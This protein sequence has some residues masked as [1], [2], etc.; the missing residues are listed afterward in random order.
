[1][2]FSP[3]NVYEFVFFFHQE[4]RVR[5]VLHKWC[6]DS[7]GDPSSRTSMLC[8]VSS[9]EV[10]DTAGICDGERANKAVS[11]QKRKKIVIGELMKVG[12][13]KSMFFVNIST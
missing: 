13:R 11:S 5:F 12:Q 10:T 7:F 6:Q 1:M 8:L 3:L 9:R 2:N 4:L